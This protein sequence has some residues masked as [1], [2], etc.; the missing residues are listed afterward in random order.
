MSH[1]QIGVSRLFIKFR[2]NLELFVVYYIEIHISES[3]LYEN[4]VTESC[5]S[6]KCI[7]QCLH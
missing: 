7:Q 6:V 5:C 3:N 2:Q 1:F 4:K